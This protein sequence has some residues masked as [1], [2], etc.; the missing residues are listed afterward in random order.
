MYHTYTLIDLLYV[1]YIYIVVD[2][3]EIK[4]KSRRAE[5]KYSNEQ[6]HDR[7]ARKDWSYLEIKGKSTS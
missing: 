6:K 2:Q 7:E 3:F 5:M 4:K 1:V